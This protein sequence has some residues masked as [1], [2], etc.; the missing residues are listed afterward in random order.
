VSVIHIPCGRPANETEELAAERGV[1]TLRT[2]ADSRRSVVLSNLAS[3]SSALH[4]SDE[5]DLVCIGP[6]GVVLVEDKHWDTAWMRDHRD[7]AEAE[8]EK[9][10]AKAKRFAGRVRALLPGAPPAVEQMLLLTPDAGRGKLDPVRSVQ[11]R[12]LRT[13]TGPNHSAEQ[14]RAGLCEFSIHLHRLRAPRDGSF[15]SI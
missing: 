4:Q 6:R 11:V 8:A 12:T 5:L 13:L 7:T 2:V 14:P 9:L 10:T 1:A 3:S 15:S